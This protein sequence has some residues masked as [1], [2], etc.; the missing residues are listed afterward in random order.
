[1][2]HR[3][4]LLQIWGSYEQL[5]VKYDPDTKAVWYTMMPKGRPCFNLDLLAE[6]HRFQGL[7]R[8]AFRAPAGRDEFPVKHMILASACPG[9]FNL[10]GDLELFSE[11]INQNDHEGL[12][13]YATAC[14]DVLYP[15]AVNFE[16]PLTTIS[17]V[18]GDALG[19]GFEAAISS[20]V[21]IAERSAK[22]G[23]PEILFNLIPGMGAY[24]FLIRRTSPAITRRLLTSGETLSAQDMFELGLVD[25]VVADGQGKKAVNNFIKE[26]DRH[27]NAHRALNRIQRLS[28]PVTYEELMAITRIW[29]E[30]ALQLTER[31]LRMIQHLIRAQNRRLNSI[32]AKP[33]KME[34]SG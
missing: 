16:L 22:F 32:E 20:N 25:E 5:S 18:Q 30:A 29:V 12:L 10:G 27:G 3:P 15:N 33:K 28:G 14:I 19:G 23:L 11:L 8:A 1:M 9:V 2:T 26:H 6:L 34:S 24:S 13:R 31:D 4:S 7:I 21:V 17:L